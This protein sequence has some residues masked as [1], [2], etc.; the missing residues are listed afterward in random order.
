MWEFQRCRLPEP[1]LA[2]INPSIGSTKAGQRGRAR[3]LAADKYVEEFLHAG[4][5]EL[6]QLGLPQLP[7]SASQIVPLAGKTID[8]AQCT[9][10][11]RFG[12]AT[13]PKSF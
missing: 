9:A 4:S 2:R 3:A 1:T 6:G 11:R 12:I 10:E 13:R 5:L 8:V 7:A